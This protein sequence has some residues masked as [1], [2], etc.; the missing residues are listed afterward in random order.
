VSVRLEGSSVEAEV[1][2]TGPGIAPADRAAV[3]ERFQRNDAG[4]AER[5]GAGLGLAIARAYARR[6]GGEIILADAP[7]LDGLQGG[8]RAVLRLPKLGSNPISDN[9]YFGVGPPH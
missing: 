3:F 9:T 1:C 5:R 2:D 8:L 4:T 6:N 7:A